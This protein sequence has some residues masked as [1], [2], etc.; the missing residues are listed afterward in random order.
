MV[1][2]Y[3]KKLEHDLL[4]IVYLMSGGRGGE[5]NLVLPIYPSR[6]MRSSTLLR[7]LINFRN[8]YVSSL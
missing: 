8:K 1:C 7:G 3:A 6:G 5:M 2:R 4:L